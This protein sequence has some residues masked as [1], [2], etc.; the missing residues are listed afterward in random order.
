MSQIQFKEV[1]PTRPPLS[2]TSTIITKNQLTKSKQQINENASNHNTNKITKRS[3]TQSQRSEKRDVTKIEALSLQHH[4]FTSDCFAWLLS[5]N[6]SAARAYQLPMLIV[7]WTIFAEYS[8]AFCENNRKVEFLK[9]S[10]PRAEDRAKS[11]A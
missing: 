10:S 1:L 4:C 5:K 8:L 11:K 2:Y 9:I 3:Q 7:I 6:F